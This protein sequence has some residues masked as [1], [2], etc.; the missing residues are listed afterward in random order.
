MEETGKYIAQNNKRVTLKLVV[1]VGLET[2]SKSKERRG[3]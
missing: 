3:W 1:S 2:K